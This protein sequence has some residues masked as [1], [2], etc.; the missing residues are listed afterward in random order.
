M[1]VIRRNQLAWFVLRGTL[2]P[3]CRG[4]SGNALNGKR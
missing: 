3:L 4:A 1:L 2:K